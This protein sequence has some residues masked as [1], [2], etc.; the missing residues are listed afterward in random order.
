MPTYLVEGTAIVRPL[1]VDAPEDVVDKYVAIEDEVAL[2]LGKYPKSP[3]G[4]VLIMDK[5]GH[6]L[7]SAVPK[8]VVKAVEELPKGLKKKAYGVIIAI[9]VREAKPVTEKKEEE[10]LIEEVEESP[11]AKATIRDKFLLARYSRFLVVLGERFQITALPTSAKLKP[12]KVVVKP[13][14]LPEMR[15]DTEALK[16]I[17]RE[18]E[19]QLVKDAVAELLRTGKAKVAVITTEGKVT[20]LEIPAS[21]LRDICGEPEKVATEYLNTFASRMIKAKLS[22][23]S[24]KVLLAIVRE[25]CRA[26]KQVKSTPSLATPTKPTTPPK[27]ATPTSSQRPTP[28]SIIPYLKPSFGITPEPFRRMVAEHLRKLLGGEQK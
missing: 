10:E 6:G 26:I 24:L 12:M 7:M 2:R 17:E 9:D 20:E 15:Q 19:E 13:K 1:Y 16:E 4:F 14:P 25:F 11:K 5:T 28:H 27:P 3:E 22:P 21:V 23:D 18:T 8:S